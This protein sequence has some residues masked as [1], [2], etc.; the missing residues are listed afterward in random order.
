ME[1]SKDQ[2]AAAE[3]PLDCR[4]GHD[5]PRVEALILD[6]I[7]KNPGRSAYAQAQYYEDV[8]QYLAP[9]ARELER[10][11]RIRIV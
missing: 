3:P 6:V 9:L 2:K 10:E 4:V 1:N 7:A 5:S 11:M 8:H